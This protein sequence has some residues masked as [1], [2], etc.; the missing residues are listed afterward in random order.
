MCLRAGMPKSFATEHVRLPSVFMSSGEAASAA[1]RK[2]HPH[3]D[4]QAARG[5]PVLVH[6]KGL[7]I[8]LLK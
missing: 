8:V 3:C 4:H 7:A 1:R 2:F 5:F 6:L